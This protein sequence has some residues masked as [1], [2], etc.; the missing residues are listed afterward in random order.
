LF[1]ALAKGGISD[2]LDNKV[3]SKL[4][5]LLF[6]PSSIEPIVTRKFDDLPL[7][8]LITSIDIGVLPP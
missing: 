5:W 3:V 1:A 2:F 8:T 6:A 4:E 7:S